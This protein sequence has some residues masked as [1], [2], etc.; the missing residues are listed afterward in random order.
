MLNKK[1]AEIIKNYPVNACVDITGFGLLGHLYSM[2]SQ[3][4]KNCELNINDIPIFE[5]LDS[6]IDT[7]NG[8][9]T[10]LFITLK[11]FIAK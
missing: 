11:E 5:G 4:N 2:I 7:N 1:A 3:S 10:K 6:I 8:D 9:I